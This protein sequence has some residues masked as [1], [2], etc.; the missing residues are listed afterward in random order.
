M[1]M[2]AFD[3]T[4][5]PDDLRTRLAAH[6]VAGVT[7]FR[8][9]NDAPA[10]VLRALTDELQAAATAT[11]GPLLIAT[12]QECGQLIA[13]AHGTTP[14]AGNM[15][16]GATRDAALAERV[17]L[18][19]GRELR[20]LGVNVDY[21]PVCDVATGALAPANGIRAFSDDP[22]LV[23][24]L[25]LSF[26]RGLHAAGVAAVPKH[27]PG[28]G[29]VMVDTHHGH[30]VIPHDMARLDS[31][32]LPPF[33]AAIDAGARM[34][35]VGH[36]ATPGISGTERTPAS[37]SRAV[38]TDLLRTQMGFGGVAISDAFDMG[39]IDQG[40]LLALEA[41][42]AVR[43]GLDLLLCVAPEGRQRVERGLL[44]AAERELIDPSDVAASLGRIRALRRWLAAAEDVD[45]DVIGCAEHGRLA[46]ELARRSIT[47][48]R[49]DESL[50]PLRLADNAKVVVIQTEPHD[51]TPADTSSTVPPMLA[52]AIRRRAPGAVGIV[53]PARPGD[54]DIAQARQA[55]EGADIAIVGTFAASM[56]PEQAEL[57]R[58][59]MATNVPTVTLAL[60]TPFDLAVYPESGVHLCTYGVLAP[61]M[62]AV[63]DVLF[64]QRGVEGRLPAAIPGLYPTGHGISR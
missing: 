55:V 57:V 14:F 40:P 29:D 58:A 28:A 10:P 33:R 32:E 24:D 25:A 52:D 53:T 27:F 62:E 4:T 2:L 51:A 3:G 45:L 6:P 48:V 38:V 19:M 56:E 18:A 16:L 37:L 60:R 35:M 15:A 13:L 34:V 63:A 30:A 50:L 36:F 49:D 61:T 59:V 5:V 41:L 21:A 46:A 11:D 64:G 43:A 26:I 8:Y 1:V 12:D 20:A 39:A 9:R 22:R 31:V 7:L 44:R 23:A 17:G 42:A 47:L 54:A